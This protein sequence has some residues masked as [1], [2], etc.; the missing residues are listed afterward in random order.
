MHFHQYCSLK[1]HNKPFY[2]IFIGKFGKISQLNVEDKSEE[3]PDD[4]NEVQKQYND[5]KNE[6][7]RKDE[8]LKKYEKKYL[9]L[10][11]KLLIMVQVH[12][13]IKTDMYQ[14]FSDVGAFREEEKKEN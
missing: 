6:S 4:E 1:D 7:I 2:F 11:S 10:I 9:E 5:L 3:I 14:K 12:C 8:E 13:E